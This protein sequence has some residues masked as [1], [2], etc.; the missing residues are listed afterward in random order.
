[1]HS[2]IELY[3]VPRS[4]FDRLESKEKIRLAKEHIYDLQEV[5]LMERNDNLISEL[6]DAIKHHEF[7]VN[8][9]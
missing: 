7:F 1:M 9:E 2:T 4:Y 3:R 6:Q 5:P 8:E